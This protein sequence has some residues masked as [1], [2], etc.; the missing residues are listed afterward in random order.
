MN[1]QIKP[2][3][4]LLIEPTNHCNL[5]CIHCPV[6]R[7]MKRPKGFLDFKIFKDII[8]QVPNLKR[9]SLNGWGESLLHKDLFKMI[10]YAKNKGTETILFATNGSLV[11][12]DIVEKT[13]NS[14]LDIIEFSLDGFAETYEKIRGHSWSKILD[15]IEN[16]LQRRRLLNVRV[17]VGL[18]FVVNEET[19]KDVGE[20]IKYWKNKV[21]YIKMQP[22]VLKKQRTTD[23]P[24]FFGKH[25]GRLIIW[26][27]GRI[28]LCCADMEGAFALGNVRYDKLQEVWNGEKLNLLREKVRLGNYPDL[29]EYCGEYEHENAPKRLVV[30]LHKENIKI[31]S[32]QQ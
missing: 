28:T 5:R 22:M 2:L 23:C 19:H 7:E 4:V 18:V 12:G 11:Q 13:L 31:L 16:F 15:I 30:D 10:D 14:P 17:K 29:C 21:D 3:K 27:D 9:L 26:W 20:F 24:E 1:E 32:R 6:N 25:D 8:D